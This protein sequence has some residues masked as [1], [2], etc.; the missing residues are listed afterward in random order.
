MKPASDSSARS[1]ASLR[2][3]AAVERR[4]RGELR[5]KGVGMLASVA[6]G[7]RTGCGSLARA[8]CAILASGRRGTRQTLCYTGLDTTRRGQMKLIGSN[9]SPYVRKV[10]VVMAEKKIDYQYELEDVW[11][12]DR[13]DRPQS[14]PL[15]K[16]P[17]PDHGR[18]R[19]GV[20]LARDRRVPRQP[21]AGASA[22]PAERA[23]ALE[24]KCW[25]ALA[26]GLLDAAVLVRLEHTQR[27]RRRAQP[28]LDRPPDG[29]GRG[30]AARRCPPAWT[31][32]RGARDGKYSLA[33]ICVGCALGYLDFRF[34][35]LGWRGAATRTWRATP[36][37]C[38]RARASS[39]PM[40]PAERGRR[41]PARHVA[42]RRCR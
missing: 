33:D 29:Q 12:P 19:R 32:S 42:V 10:R 24:V 13:L 1:G 36:T 5:R 21:H 34:A 6:N 38:S 31:T 11:S 8:T 30:G 27:D 26:D 4:Q 14:N 17:M 3:V 9:T 7:A 40:P 23:L 39:T 18:R 35:Q 22:D 2:G 25:E 41:P 37:S 16:V 28:D 20:R 15:G